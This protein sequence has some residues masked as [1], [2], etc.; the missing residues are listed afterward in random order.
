[1]YSRISSRAVLVL[2]LVGCLVIPAAAQV[3]GNITGYVRDPSGAA[4][5]N[6][7]VSAKMIEQQTTRTITTDTDGFYT[8][9][10]LPPGKYD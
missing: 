9:I 2:A 10:A 4:I 7:T 6:V 8:F 3:T 5:P 1:M